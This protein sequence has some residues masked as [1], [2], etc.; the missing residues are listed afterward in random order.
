MPERPQ[1][2]DSSLGGSKRWSC[3]TL[4]EGIE[5]VQGAAHNKSKSLEEE[6]LLRELQDRNYIKKTYDHICGF[7]LEISLQKFNH[8][9]FWTQI[10][11]PML[12][13]FPISMFLCSYLSRS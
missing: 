10:I 13:P 6:Q 3:G 9:S 2:V 7:D 5:H 1:S 8:N 12:V 4:E 11:F